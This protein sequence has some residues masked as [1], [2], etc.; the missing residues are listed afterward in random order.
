MNNNERLEYLTHLFAATYKLGAA[1]IGPT[2]TPHVHAT[3]EINFT[4]QSNV[5]LLPK[6]DRD[7]FF[8]YLKS[9]YGNNGE[10]V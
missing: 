1:Y 4:W 3:L 2:G 10:A 7:V 9:L 8:S 6:G 5:D